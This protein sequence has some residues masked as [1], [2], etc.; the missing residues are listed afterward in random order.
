MKMPAVV[1]NT[2]S[3]TKSYLS[4]KTATVV[5]LLVALLGTYLLLVSHASYVTPTTKLSGVYVGGSP[6][7]AAAYETWR[8][9]PV[10]KVLIFPAGKT[11]SDIQ[12]VPG[13]YAWSSTTY[14]DKMV[15]GIKMLPCDD[16]TANL[17]SGANGAYDSYWKAAAQKLISYGESNAIIR[18]GW[19]FNQGYPCY[20]IKP[21]SP[22]ARTGATAANYIAY[23][24]HIVTAMRSVP[25]QNFTFLW[26]PSNGNLGFDTS[27]AYPGDNYV[28]YLGLDTYDTLYNVSSCTN[29]TFTKRWDNIVNSYGT[30]PQ[31]LNFWD[32]FAKAH[33]KPLAFPEW[34]LWGSGTPYCGGGDDPS[35]I[36]AMHDWIGSHNVYY[37]SYFDVNAN[38]GSHYIGPGSSS[39]PNAATKYVSLFKSPYA[40]T[41]P[42]TADTTPPTVSIASPTPGS[43]VKGLVAVQ[44]NA[45]DNQAIQK[46]EFYLDGNLKATDTTAP[47]CLAGDNGTS[48]DA[49]DSTSVN[50]GS[51]SLLAK[52]YDASNNTSSSNATVT[53]SNGSTTLDTTP[54]SAYI[55]TPAAGAK[56]KGKI[57]ILAGATDN[58]GVVWVEISVDNVVQASGATNSL[59]FVWSANSKSVSSG[60][61]TISVL[62]KDLAGNIGTKSIQVHK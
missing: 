47:Y 26:N 43:T 29:S 1:T 20:T 16:A 45:A 25:G 50:D 56:V 55:S 37:E 58:T 49:W 34:G 42:T 21:G 52:A 17:Q 3:Y 12:S 59:S 53:V 22:N 10:D 19:E 46:V 38:D 48:C 4:K 6:S 15:M 24:Q 54:P 31:G 61:H 35:Y 13:A 5:I 60:N 23:F 27:S 11:W 2:F 32:S 33:S 14:K 40:G 41:F 36:Q 57:N 51:H 39:Y 8:G 28:D 30:Y 18:T 9:R 7:S 62:A 44:A